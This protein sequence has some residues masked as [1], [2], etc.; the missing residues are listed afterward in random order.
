MEVRALAEPIEQAEPSPAR[1]TTWVVGA[2]A[3]RSF[4]AGLS[5]GHAL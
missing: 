5:V 1:E 2:S 4:W 3:S